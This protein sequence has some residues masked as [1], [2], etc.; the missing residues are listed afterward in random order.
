MSWSKNE[1]AYAEAVVFA[2][3]C[4]LCITAGVALGLLVSK[5]LGIV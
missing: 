1:K 3:L 4:T 2:V 5:L